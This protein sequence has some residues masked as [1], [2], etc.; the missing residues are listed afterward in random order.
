MG[1]HLTP[2]FEMSVNRRIPAPQKPLK[3]YVLQWAGT[4]KNLS[5]RIGPPDFF[6][7]SSNYSEDRLDKDKYSFPV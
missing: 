1:W 5:D 3:K 4:G 2:N 6:P 7:L